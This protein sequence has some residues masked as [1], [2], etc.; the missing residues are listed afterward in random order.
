MVPNSNKL[1]AL[2]SDMWFYSLVYLKMSSMIKKN[3][4]YTTIGIQRQTT[5]IHYFLFLCFYEIRN[6]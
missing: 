2:K 1:V 5:S 6:R 3:T 4:M